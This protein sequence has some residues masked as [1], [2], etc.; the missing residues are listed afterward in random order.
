MNEIGRKLAH[1]VAELASVRQHQENP[2]D[3]HGARGG[4]QK[5]HFFNFFFI[6]PRSPE[7]RPESKQ[8][9]QT[10]NAA[11]SDTTRRQLRGISDT[12][13]TCRV[14]I[15]HDTGGKCYCGEVAGLLWE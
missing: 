13:A 12:N 10:K 6:T 15:G 8:T 2:A 7:R 1:T 9:T 11:L 3:H 14:L 5:P 4:G